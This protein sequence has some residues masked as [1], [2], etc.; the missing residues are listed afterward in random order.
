MSLLFEN[1]K[2]EDELIDR[3]S[4]TRFT[5]LRFENSKR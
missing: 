1:G 4:Y 3:D 2:I 5:L